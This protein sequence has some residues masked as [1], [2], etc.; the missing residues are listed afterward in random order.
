MIGRIGPARQKA[1]GHNRTVFV[2][3][4]I[5]KNTIEELVMRRLKTKESVQELLLN[6]VKRRGAP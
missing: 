3:N 4:I 1:S 6:A 2:Y 5:A